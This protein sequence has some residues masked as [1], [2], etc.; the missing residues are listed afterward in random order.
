[1][2]RQLAEMRRI[3]L[4]P[5]P[6]DHLANTSLYGLLGLVCTFLPRGFQLKILSGH[7][8]SSIH[9][10]CPKHFNSLFEFFQA[11][12]LSLPFSCKYLGPDFSSFWISIST[13]KILLLIYE[14][15]VHA[16]QLLLKTDYFSIALLMCLLLFL[17]IWGLEIES[18]QLFFFLIF[19]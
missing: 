15:F 6:L 17:D 18:W 3:S 11:W 13:F 10:R 16:S 14:F 9:D 19:K 1:M 12:L 7:H 4:E 8:S 2:E 5:M